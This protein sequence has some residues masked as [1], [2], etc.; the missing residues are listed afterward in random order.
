M[1]DKRAHLTRK[2]LNELIDE[3]ADAYVSERESN[4]WCSE[5]L[6]YLSDFIYWKGLD[7]EFQKFRKEAIEEVD[8]D[9]P[10]PHLV[11]PTAG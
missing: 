9:N 11:M 6:R 7:E 5:E 4:E 2:E 3:I 10:F 1:A 8:P